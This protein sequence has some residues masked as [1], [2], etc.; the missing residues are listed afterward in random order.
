MTQ[1]WSVKPLARPTFTKLAEK[2][3]DLLEESLRQ[4]N[5]KIN[6]S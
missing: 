4:V 5:K 3:G 6:I 1:C 2:L